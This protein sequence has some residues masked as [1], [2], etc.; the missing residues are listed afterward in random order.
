[1]IYELTRVKR[2]L[3]ILQIQQST[4]QT[5]YRSKL[6]L[7]K[8]AKKERGFINNF[9]VLTSLNRREV[10]KNKKQV[11]SAKKRENGKS[12]F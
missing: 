12:D 8:S 11:K 5:V 9:E 10:S 1:M 7:K 6:Q 3:T 4:H 2:N